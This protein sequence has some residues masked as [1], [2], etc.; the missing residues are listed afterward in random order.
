MRKEKFHSEV[1]SRLA[2]LAHPYLGPF[3]E[4]GRAELVAPPVIT[5]RVPQ[6]RRFARPT[7]TRHIKA[8]AFAATMFQ[9]RRAPLPS[10]CLPTVRPAPVPH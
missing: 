9:L 1:L 2:T 10:V 6:R 5:G 8:F 4:G 7:F 3:S